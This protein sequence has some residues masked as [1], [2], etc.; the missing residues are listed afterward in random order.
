MKI[1]SKNLFDSDATVFFDVQVDP[2]Q[3]Y[4]PKIVSKHLKDGPA[5]SN[6]IHIMEPELSAEYAQKYLKYI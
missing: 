1:S 3:T 6:P 2:E 4:F 5:I